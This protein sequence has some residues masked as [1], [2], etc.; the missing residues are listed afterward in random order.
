M[1]QQITSNKRH[2]LYNFLVFFNAFPKHNKSTEVFIVIIQRH[3]FDFV[4]VKISK[5]MLHLFQLRNWVSVH[6]EH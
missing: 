4:T 2:L 3:I 5:Q 6:I 1:F